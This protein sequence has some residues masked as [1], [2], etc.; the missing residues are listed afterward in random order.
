MNPSTGQVPRLP[1]AFRVG[2]QFEMCIGK[3]LSRKLPDFLARVPME[4]AR[5]KFL[6][7]EQ[8]WTALL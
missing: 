4:A 7:K 8:E 5:K 1:A 3:Q 2:L 6:S